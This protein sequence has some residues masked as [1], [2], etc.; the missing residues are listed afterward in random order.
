MVRLRETE[1]P[2]FHLL[3]QMIV[4]IRA[5]DNDYAGVWAEKKPPRKHPGPAMP[6][7]SRDQ[8]VSA[9]RPSDQKTAGPYDLCAQ[10][11]RFACPPKQGRTFLTHGTHGPGL[12]A[13]PRCS[14]SAEDIKP[15][16]GILKSARAGLPPRSAPL[17]ILSAPQLPE[18]YPLHVLY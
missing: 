1:A 2:N 18:E 15:L 6:V 8:Q 5:I 4:Q 3:R 10:D 16:H 7:P 14:P 13:N 9:P 17:A 12:P 11:C